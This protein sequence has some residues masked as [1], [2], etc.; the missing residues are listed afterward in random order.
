LP[1]CFTF[2]Y[3]VQGDTVWQPLPGKLSPADLANLQHGP[4]LQETLSVS[5]NEPAQLFILDDGTDVVKLYLV[6]GDTTWLVVPQ[7]IT[8]QQMGNLANLTTGGTLEGPL[9]PE[10]LGLAAEPRATTPGSGPAAGPDTL[11]DSVR[12]DILAA[13]DRANAAWIAASQSLDSSSLDGNVAGQELTDDL[14][15]IDTLR[16]QGHTETNVNTLFAVVD[17]Q[18][19]AAGH[20]TVHTRETWSSETRAADTDEVLQRTP[21]RTYQETYTV[22]YQDAGWIVTKNDL[23]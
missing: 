18:L 23:S 9:P 13:V 22:E 8:D 7:Q 14:A 10:L 17:V 5:R 11:T 1:R 3:I 20:A 4:D 21:P 19:N 6:Q 12:T 15:Q 16:N 2:L